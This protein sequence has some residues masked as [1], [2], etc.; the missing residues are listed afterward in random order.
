MVCVA[1]VGVSIFRN[2]GDTGSSLTNPTEL[3]TAGMGHAQRM[4]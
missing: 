2:E 1:D 3:S 4:G